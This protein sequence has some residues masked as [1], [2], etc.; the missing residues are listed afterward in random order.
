MQNPPATI[1][2]IIT[3]SIFF[4]IIAKLHFEKRFIFHLVIPRLRSLPDTQEDQYQYA[5]DGEM[6]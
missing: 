3:T 4:S 6:G 1:N 5:T 2:I